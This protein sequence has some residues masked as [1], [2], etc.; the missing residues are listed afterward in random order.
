MIKTACIKRLRA[1]IAFSAAFAAVLLPSCVS[2][3]GGDSTETAAETTY[4]SIS[5]S[6]AAE[7]MKADDGHII[8]DV[9]RTDEF[10]ESH[11]PGAVCIP[12]ETIG[13]ARPEQLP[14]LDRIILVYCRSGRRSKEA[15]GKLAAMGYTAVYEFG[16]IIDWTGETVSGN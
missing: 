14:D 15:A 11:I 7:M 6:E 4:R 2:P 10:A 1:V 16:G 8:V 12:N 3:A 13:T 5:Q 9:R